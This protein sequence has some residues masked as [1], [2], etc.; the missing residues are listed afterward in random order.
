[1]SSR[2]RLALRITAVLAGLLAA[3]LGAAPASAA[4]DARIAQSAPAQ[5]ATWSAVPGPVGATPIAG[6]PHVIN[7][8]L[9]G[10]VVAQYFQ[11][12]NTGSLDLTGQ[13]YSA[14]NSK[15]TNGNAPPAIGLDACIGATWNTVL[16]T[17]AGTVVRIVAT[18]QSAIASTTAIRAGGSLSLRA[19]PITLPNFPQPYTTTVSVSVSLSQTRTATITNT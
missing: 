16:G 7:W 5:S 8:N 11:V 15:A 19:M 2:P 3:A 14:V 1:M 10:I 18:T 17:C 9:S 13:T 6:Q 4:I 12:A